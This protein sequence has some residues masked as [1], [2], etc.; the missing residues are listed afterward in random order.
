MGARDGAP[1]AGYR[2]HAMP[3]DIPPSLRR[4]LLAPLEAGGR[5]AEVERRIEEAIELGALA[6]AEQLPSESEL[7][8]SLGVAPMTLREALVGLRRSGLVETRRGR[9]GGTFVRGSAEAQRTRLLARLAARSAD[10]LRDLGDEHMALAA[11]AAALAAERASDED[12]DHLETHVAALAGADGERA[13]RAADSRFHIELAAAARSLRLTQALTRMQADVAGLT[14]I[15]GGAERAAPAARE[16]RAIL[17]ALR[18]RD[19]DAAARAMRRHLERET[20]VLVARRIALY[21]AVDGDPGSGRLS[22]AAMERAL[23]HVEQALDGVFA[24][25]VRARELALREMGT[26]WDTTRLDELQ[27]WMQEQLRKRDALASGLGMALGQAAPV[28]GPRWIWWRSGAARPTPLPVERDVMHPEYYDYESAAWYAGPCATGRPAITG[29]FVDHGAADDH[30]F[31]PAVPISSPE[32]GGGS[33]GVVGADVRVARLEAVVLPALLALP[34]EATLLNGDGVVIA[35]SAASWLPG[36]RWDRARL[37]RL[38]DP[39]AR[40]AR[41]GGERVLTSARLGWT[42]VATVR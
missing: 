38:Q 35:S 28:T 4:S 8:A 31:T 11:A 21:E 14:W 19:G 2:A 5:A 33:V 1:T 37:K 24:S 30:I 42:L 25:L 23:A 34:G 12:L 3:S 20:A 26:P 27:T 39:S 32:P 29:P 13:A 40:G 17:A 15:V 18:K 10:Q 6:D 9:S 22:R 41:D 36:Q 16:H 7:A